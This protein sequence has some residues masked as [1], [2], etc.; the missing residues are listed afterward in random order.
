MTPTETAR[1]LD[2]ITQTVALIGFTGLVFVAFLIFYDGTARYI[3]APR[4][5]GFTD[6]G[7]VIYPI[8]IA[9]CFPAGLLR[10]TNVTIRVFG[11][12]G[13]PRLNAALE[14]LAA[15]IVLAFFAILVWQFFVLVGKYGDA[16]RT[17]RTIGI[18]LAPFW[19]V[20]TAVMA[21]C[22]PVQ[23]YVLVAWLRAALTGGPAAHEGLAHGEHAPVTE[24]G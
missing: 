12:V 3:G 9:S 10:Q 5:H 1:Q 2:R 21:L 20:T 23:V 8:V 14:A 13:G 15:A 16:G 6:Y 19:W 11:K 4:I 18:P 24:A 7:E 22:I 17:T